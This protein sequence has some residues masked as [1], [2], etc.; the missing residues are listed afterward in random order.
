MGIRLVDLQAARALLLIID[1]MTHALYEMHL[2]GTIV[3]AIHSTKISGLR[4]ENLLGANGSRQGPEGLISFH[5]QKEFHAHLK[6]R[7]LD[8]C[9]MYAC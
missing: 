3:G 9:C 1:I 4:F 2:Q 5:S 7:M 8:G 6:W